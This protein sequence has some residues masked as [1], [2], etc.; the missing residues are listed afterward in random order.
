MKVVES[1]SLYPISELLMG[2]AGVYA[3]IDGIYRCRIL[4]PYRPGASVAL[5]ILYIYI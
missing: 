3:V 5:D 1:S 2:I 4:M